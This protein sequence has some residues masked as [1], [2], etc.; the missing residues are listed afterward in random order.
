[1]YH[2]NRGCPL[3]QNPA[4]TKDVADHIKLR[5]QPRLL[6]ELQER[7]GRGPVV[8]GQDIDFI[9]VGNHPWHWRGAQLKESNGT[10]RGIVDQLEALGVPYIHLREESKFCR[11]WRWVC[12]INALHTHFLA[13]QHAAN[14]TG[15]CHNF[16]TRTDV[17]SWA[18]KCARKDSACIGCEQCRGT[19]AWEAQQKRKPRYF[20][21]T[22]LDDV[23][24]NRLPVDKDILDGM[25]RAYGTEWELLAGTTRANWPPQGNFGAFEKRV[26]PWSHFHNQGHS[27]V[28]GKYDTAARYWS[29][30]KRNEF[31]LTAN[32]FGGRILDDQTEVRALHFSFF[33]CVR[34]DSL[35]QFIMRWDHN[36]SE[37][38]CPPDEL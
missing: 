4:T 5:L 35:N 38:P 11:Y 30:T 20:M 31:S 15:V 10:T 16:C 18:E 27:S 1:V 13:Y 24:L 32:G 29:E 28:F 2:I 12:K 19:P 23:V 14:R 34:L 21:V 33:P 22:D 3:R 36:T 9:F 7:R 25:H 6:A 26:N 8:M 37:F 17:G